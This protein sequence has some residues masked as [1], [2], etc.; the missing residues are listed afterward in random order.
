MGDGT[1]AT[2]SQQDLGARANLSRLHAALR[3]DRIDAPPAL[4]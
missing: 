1:V 3:C 2:E 4:G